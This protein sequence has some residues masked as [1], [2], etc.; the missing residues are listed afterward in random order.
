[1]QR[2]FFFGFVFLMFNT[3]FEW[4][5]KQERYWSSN[6]GLIAEQKAL[7]DYYFFC[8]VVFIVDTFFSYDLRLV[9]CEALRGSVPWERL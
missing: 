4:V 8:I 7:F 2:G 3:R 6:T 1:M 9:D 5:C